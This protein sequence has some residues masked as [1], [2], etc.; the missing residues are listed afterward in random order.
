MIYKYVV[1]K[2]RQNLYIYIY[3]SNISVCSVLS[4]DHNNDKYSISQY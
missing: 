1:E 2:V 4:I 3:I